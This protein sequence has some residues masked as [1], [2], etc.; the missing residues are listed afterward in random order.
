[1]DVHLAILNAQAQLSALTPFRFGMDRESYKHALAAVEAWVEPFLELKPRPT[2]RLLG[3]ARRFDAQRLIFMA[4]TAFD[5]A[6]AELLATLKEAAAAANALQDPHAS[7]DAPTRASSQSDHASAQ[8]SATAQPISP[9]SEVETE[10]RRIELI[11]TPL[12]KL[13]DLLEKGFALSLSTLKRQLAELCGDDQL[14][15]IL[16]NNFAEAVSCHAISSFKSAAIMAGASAEGILLA[17]LKNVDDQRYADTYAATFPQRK[18]KSPEHLSFEESVSLA[19][20]LGLLLSG[21]RHFSRG[22]K[23]LRNLVHPALEWREGSSVSPGASELAIRSALLLLH[24][25]VAGK[26]LHKAD[27]D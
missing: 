7:S 9:A 5:D 15:A 10:P 27:Q 26:S 4:P 6:R 14:R 19:E 24:D 16:L 3:L 2:Q 17:A 25:L 12:P 1:M 21:T 11:P 18:A 23:D 13:A 20:A 8:P 22:I